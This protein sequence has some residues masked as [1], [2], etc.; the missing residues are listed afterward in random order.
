M[1]K[2]GA[3]KDPGG[4]QPDME[5]G[6]EAAARKG[7]KPAEQTNTAGSDTKPGTSSLDK[8]EQTAAEI[9]RRNAERDTGKK[10]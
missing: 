4:E 7:V 10:A 3:T 6:L 5:R 8:E 1:S 9:Y 2:E